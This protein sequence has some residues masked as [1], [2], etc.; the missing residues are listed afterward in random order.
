VDVPLR[1]QLVLMRSEQIEVEMSTY[2]IGPSIFSPSV[3]NLTAIMIV[4]VVMFMDAGVCPTAG[5]APPLESF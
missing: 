3:Q 2:S 4:K 1:S 5:C